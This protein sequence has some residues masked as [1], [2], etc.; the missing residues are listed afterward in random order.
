MNDVKK[1]KKLSTEVTRSVCIVLGNDCKNPILK[2]MLESMFIENP[3][4]LKKN[5]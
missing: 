2:L 5:I 3:F 4:Q 1:Q